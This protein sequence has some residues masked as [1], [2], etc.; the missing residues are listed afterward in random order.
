MKKYYRL[1]VFIITTISVL[2][3]LIYRSEYKKL[4]STFEIGELFGLDTFGYDCLV[5]NKSIQEKTKYNNLF[6]RPSPQWV[7]IDEFYVFSAFWRNVSEKSKSVAL[8]ISLKDND[9]S[10]YECHIWYHLRGSLF[11][12][13]GKFS[14]TSKKTKTSVFINEFFC[15]V[16]HISIKGSPYMFVFVE[17]IPNKKYFIPIYYKLKHE[18]LNNAAVCVFPDI[19]GLERN[20][21]IEFIS[22][23]KLVGFNDV[24]VYDNGMHH[25]I[26]AILENLFLNTDF[27]RSF[28]FLNWQFPIDDIEVQEEFIKLDCFYRV[29]DQ[30]DIVTFLHWDEYI[31]PRKGKDIHSLFNHLGLSR[32]IQFSL[33]IQRCCTELKNDMRAKQSWPMM[34]KKTLCTKHHPYRTAVLN[35][36]A[37]SDQYFEDVSSSLAIVNSYDSCEMLKETKIIQDK[38]ALKFI[39]DLMSNELLRISRSGI[40]N[41][42]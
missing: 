31:I 14:Y 18:K 26:L 33:E 40:F 38:I 2:G 1:A 37:F 4:R 19:S 34:L 17:K 9:Y 35:P 41:E 3:F 16:D 36:T 30:V 23:H 24:I 10:K 21:I 27:L 28:S 29:F 6:S 25:G 13:S 22:Y 32:S 11:S 39:A 5:L 8:G 42:N 7:K 15:E 12:V 20:N